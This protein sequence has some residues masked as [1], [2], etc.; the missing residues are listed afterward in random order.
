MKFNQFIETLEKHGWSATADA[1]HEIIKK[2][3][4]EMFPHSAAIEKELEEE[5]EELTLAADRLNELSRLIN[6]SDGV[7]GYHLNGDVAPW[8][9][10]EYIKNGT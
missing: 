9:E 5:R 3:W 8:S 1:Q 4:K 6:Q 2:A 10:F 7:A